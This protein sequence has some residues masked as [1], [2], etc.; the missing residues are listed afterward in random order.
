MLG[1]KVTP[2]L[3]KLQEHFIKTGGKFKEYKIGSIFEAQNGN[4]DIQQKHINNQ[5]CYVVSSGEQNMGIIGKTDV[6]AKIFEKNTI[7]IDMF[8][9][10]YFRDFNYK[11]VTHARV[12][13]LKYKFKELTRREGMYFVSQ[14]SYLKKVFSY[15]NMASF[16]K[17]KD[18][19]IKLPTSKEEKIDFYFMNEYIR[20]LEEDR[21]SKLTDYL[22]VSELDNYELSSSE[23]HSLHRLQKGVSMASFRIGDLFDVN[24]SKKKYNANVIKFGGKYPY[25]ARGS[26]NNGIRGFITESEEFLNA[27][28][29]ISFGQDTATIFYQEKPYF[30]G[31]KIKILT[32]KYGELNQELAC[33]LIASM[34]RVFN[35]FSWGQNS[36]NENV[37]KN[38][39]I[40]LPIHSNNEIDFEFMEN[41][42][43]AIEK[44]TIKS[45]IEWKD[46]IMDTFLH[47][48]SI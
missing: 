16:A 7:T 4:F 31:D 32:Y 11:M 46:Q 47:A 28:K 33:Y 12:F 25:V 24:S 40:K 3:I 34:K 35:N 27:Q 14:F 44:L 20:E 10:S 19:T 39:S 45:V 42:I 15:S 26:S 5:G 43:K 8:G 17:I 36:F 13:S 30:T 1:K 6:D 22:K 23:K 29:T 38:T 18:R 9:N 21:I 41:Y 37:I 2:A 48:K